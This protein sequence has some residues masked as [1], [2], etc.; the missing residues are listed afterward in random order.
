MRC[1][2]CSNAARWIV[3]NRA[4]FGEE[5]ERPLQ[6]IN[7]AC[8]NHLTQLCRESRYGETDKLTVQYLEAC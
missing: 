8:G 5:P 6:D 7:Y 3:Q 2:Y 4:P 1:W